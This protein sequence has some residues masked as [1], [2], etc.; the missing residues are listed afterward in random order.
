MNAAGI[1]PA[2]TWRNSCFATKRVTETLRTQKLA[3]C[4]LGTFASVATSVSGRRYSILRLRMAIGS[5][6]RRTSTKLKSSE[7]LF[8]GRF[9]VVEVAEAARGLLA[10]RE[11]H[12]LVRNDD[13][14]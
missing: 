5:R 2:I 1:E 8:T 9:A 13:R 4:I 7:I 12:G 11:L 10:L 14:C 3:K 6:A